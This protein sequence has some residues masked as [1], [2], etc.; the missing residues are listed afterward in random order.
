MNKEI[1]KRELMKVEN[2]GEKTAEYLIEIGIDS[3]EKL[4]RITE[5]EL[6]NKFKDLKEKGGIDY[7][8]KTVK[9]WIE[10]AKTEDY[11]YSI[12]I[13]KYKQLLDRSFDNENNLILFRY[14]KLEGLEEWKP[15]KEDFN[16]NNYVAVEYDKFYKDKKKVEEWNLT[17]DKWMK[18]SRY[19][20][21]KEK[22]KSI[23][24][25]IFYDKL[26]FVKFKE[27]YGEDGKS[28]E[29]FYCHITEKEIEELIEAGKITT[30]RLYSRGRRMEIEQKEPD[31]GYVFSNIAL[32]CYWC[33]N[34]KSDEFTEEEFIPL[35]KEIEKIWKKRLK[36]NSKY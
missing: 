29:C 35:G 30:K 28:R 18:N 10:S 2:V 17:Y 14:L 13:S 24:E 23:F 31:K 1:S 7:Y 20:Y 4:A 9:P 21:I 25:N 8:V 33:N 22:L 11:K 5:D 19:N 12:A 27:L 16:N 6:I 26:R 32:C 34:A 15:T 36:I 3:P